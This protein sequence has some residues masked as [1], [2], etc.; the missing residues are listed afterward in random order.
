MEIN[1][2]SIRNNIWRKL[3]I[4]SASTISLWWWR[5][6]KLLKFLPLLHQLTLW[7][8]SLSIT[9][10]NNNTILK[11]IVDIY[12][13]Q[14]FIPDLPVQLCPKRSQRYK[15]H[16]TVINEK[17]RVINIF[18]DW[19]RLRYYHYKSFSFQKLRGKF[20]VQCRTLPWYNVEKP[21]QGR[22]DNN[23]IYAR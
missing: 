23:Y 1:I 20:K 5:C 17:L 10:E 18:N 3:L 19:Q 14:F 2:D 7:H 12:S 16:W 9:P 6:S 21:L 22:M 4:M 11:G 8:W 15:L 13:P